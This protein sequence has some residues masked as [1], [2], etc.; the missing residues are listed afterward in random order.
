MTDSES[1]IEKLLETVKCYPNLKISA[2]ELRRPSTDTVV[3]IYQEILRAMG[4]DIRNLRKPLK[5][6]TQFH[7][8]YYDTDFRFIMKLFSV[9]T[10][11]F[12]EASHNHLDLMDILEPN[13]HQT[14][15]AVAI[16]HN[17]QVFRKSRKEEIDE[18]V[19][20]G[21][22]DIEKYKKLA[23]HKEKLRDEINYQS[24]QKAKL[25]LLLDK[26]KSQISQAEVTVFTLIEEKEKIKESLEP[27]IKTLAE[28]DNKISKAETEG[29]K[30]GQI[31]EKLKNQ[32]VT[33]PD[34]LVQ[35]L[36][37]LKAA[38]QQMKEE[39][40]RIS[41]ELQEKKSR[42][43]KLADCAQ[44]AKAVW[45]EIKDINKE[46]D[47]N[48]NEEME[49][50]QLETEKTKLTEQISIKNEVV[51]WMKQTEEDLQKKIKSLEGYVVDKHKEAQ[52]KISELEKK[53]AEDVRTIEE[54]KCKKQE[55]A[56][57]L[58][59]YKV[60]TSKQEE[61]QKYVLLKMQSEVKDVIQEVKE[62]TAAFNMLSNS[63]SQPR[64]P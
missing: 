29:I 12:K 36:E 25:T 21:S 9:L 34:Q 51:R 3:S 8:S 19:E 1:T 44:V 26:L 13:I 33:S 42:C 6:E 31:I 50:S 15:A 64:G 4:V 17:F 16:L 2:A 63:F 23:A 60:K 40:L 61:K 62:L 49:L 10:L 38:E 11:L 37:N 24:K 59:E 30:L 41:E 27:L 7:L 46:I 53:I 57:A 45:Q 55:C 52:L 20:Q 32:I 39:E 48:R 22:E 18:I 5:S 14:H 43:E 56:K 28:C 58:E 35:N 47:E 54:Y